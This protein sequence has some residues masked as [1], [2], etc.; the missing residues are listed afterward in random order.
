MFQDKE[1]KPLN[2]DDLT[3]E[4]LEQLLVG[5]KQQQQDTVQ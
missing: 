4:Q 5:A 1:P 2:V 3:E